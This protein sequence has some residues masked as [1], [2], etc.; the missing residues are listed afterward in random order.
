MQIHELNTLNRL[1]KETDYLAIDTGFDTA[2]I[3][4]I[5]LF[6]DDYT[7]HKAV[8]DWLDK[9]PEATTTVADKAIT[10]QK[11]SDELADEIVSGNINAVGF[12][13]TSCFKFSELNVSGMTFQSGT[14]DTARDHFVLV[15]SDD[16][17]AKIITLA[18]DMSILGIFTVD[19]AYHAN[20][21]TYD[22]DQD[23]LYLATST[24]TILVLDPDDMSVI[25]SIIFEAKV[26]SIEYSSAEK[27]FYIGSTSETC[28]I[29]KCNADMTGFEEYRVFTNESVKEQLSL[30][31][32]TF[33]V[34]QS[35]CYCNGCLYLVAYTWDNNAGVVSIN[36]YLLMIGKSDIYATRFT[37]SFAGEEPEALIRVG[38]AGVLASWRS[39]GENDSQIILYK[40]YM[41]NSDTK[42]SETLER[43]V[44]IK[45]IDLND[46]IL[47]GIYFS[48]NSEDTATIQNA[49]VSTSFVLQV[50]SQ[51]YEDSR[52]ILFASAT[53]K[54][55]TR[56]IYLSSGYVENWYEL[57]LNN[58]AATWSTLTMPGDSNTKF[59]YRRINNNQVE[60]KLELGGTT[61]PEQSDIGTLPS[62]FVPPGGYYFPLTR[63][64]N[65]GQQTGCNA[66]R[67]TT[68]GV[69]QII[70]VENYLHGSGIY[71]TT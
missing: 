63:W 23:R 49:P 71:S 13:P 54:I 70:A 41:S 51:G 4:A 60:W 36:G 61:H 17:I 21:I 57:L 25:T 32:Q 7:V 64:G 1:P 59:F 37:T 27:L 65:N 47:P 35:L 44:T 42:V 39:A 16:T 53:N 50:I 33:L 29:Y 18:P 20:D 31:E 48:R 11:L 12:K 8:T 5:N 26:D 2:K 62:E 69:V 56:V 43:G 34:F 55:Y 67:I 6:A 9:H 28:T 3:P 40:A 14:Y 66:L 52:Q 68:N 15:F 38:N 58:T 30:D 22:L 45:N 10:D 19:E 24:T 46:V